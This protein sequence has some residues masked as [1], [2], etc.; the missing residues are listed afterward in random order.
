MN[1]IFGMNINGPGINGFGAA[2]DEDE[3]PR[4]DGYGLFRK[5]APLKPLYETT[6]AP[7]SVNKMRK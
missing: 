2:E 6:A 4:V 3:S 1:D 5:G 7:G